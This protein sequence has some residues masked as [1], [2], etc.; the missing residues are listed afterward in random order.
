MKISMTVAVAGGALLVACLA[1]RNPGTP[2]WSA[3]RPRETRPLESASPASGSAPADPSESGAGSPPPPIRKR[4]PGLGEPRTE[5]DFKA[6]NGLLDDLKAALTSGGTSPAEV[7]DLF[8]GESRPFILDVLAMALREGPAPEELAPVIPRLVSIG[9]GEGTEGQRRSAF[10]VLG[11]VSDPDGRVLAALSTVAARDR[12]P[13]L[14]IAA[15]GAL[16][17]RIDTAP[18]TTEPIH[19]AL[20]AIASSGGDADVRGRAFAAIDGSALS[21]ERLADVARIARN[22]PS[23]DVRLS[24]AEVLGRAPASYRETG[25]REIEHAYLAERRPDRRGALLFSLVQLGRAA[26]ADTLRRLPEQDPEVVRQIGRY[27]A[28]L[29]SGE[30][31]LMR[32]ADRILQGDP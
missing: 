4:L 14:R 20:L 31:D 8:V 22:D 32:I 28:I 11:M 17:E 3:S 7:V 12:D 9:L 25:L 1:A 10:L 24:A 30:T 2:L 15:I 19:R 29:D 26:A 13:D 27:L 16:H 21:P 6:L 23:P 18:G 5:E